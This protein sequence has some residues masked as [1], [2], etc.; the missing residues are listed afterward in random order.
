[1]RTF[2]ETLVSGRQMEKHEFIG[3]FWLKPGLQK[4][5]LNNFRKM[6][7]EFTWHVNDTGSNNI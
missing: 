7:L 2:Q 1:M 3:P 5:C 4:V 6:F